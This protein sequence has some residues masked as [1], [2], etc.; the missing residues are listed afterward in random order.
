[1]DLVNFLGQVGAGGLAGFAVGYAAKKILKLALLILGLFILAIG[2]L[3]YQGIVQVSMEDL[4]SWAEAQLGSLSSQLGGLVNFIAA[5]SGL[6]AGFIGGL[7]L[8]LKKG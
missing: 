7:I 2:Y 4:V 3:N 1:M 6:G 5:N 8:G